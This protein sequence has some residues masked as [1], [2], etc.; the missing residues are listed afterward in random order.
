MKKILILRNGLVMVLFLSLAFNV[1][2]QKKSSEEINITQFQVIKKDTKVVIN[3]TTSK[4]S[5][6]NYF[7]VERSADGKNFNTIAYVLGADP[8]KTDCECFGCFDKVSKKG[9]SFYRLK[10]VNTDGDVQFSEVKM[11]ALK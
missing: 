7:E 2:A 6:T 11:L 3:W 5:P 10:H 8:T 9:K 4:D 1:N